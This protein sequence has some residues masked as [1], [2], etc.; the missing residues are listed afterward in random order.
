V[1]AEPDARHGLPAAL[2]GEARSKPGG[3]VYEIVGDY[4]PDGAEPPEAIRGAWRV[5]DQGEVEGE[6]IE[7]PNYGP[8]ALEGRGSRCRR[9]AAGVR[10]D[11]ELPHGPDRSDSAHWKRFFFW[12]VRHRSVSCNEASA[13]SVSAEVP[14]LLWGCP[15]TGKIS[16]ARAL[17]EA[18]GWLVEVVIGSIRDPSDIAELPV[19]A[20]SSVALAPAWAR[21]LASASEGLR[22]LDDLTT[23]PA[24]FQAAMLHIF[25]ARVVGD[26]WRWRP[27]DKTSVFVGLLDPAGTV[28]GW[29]KVDNLEP[30]G[31]LAGW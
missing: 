9:A 10:P 15:G 29:A 18:L 31:S 13:V 19:V 12:E 6:F 4:D 27:P 20:E 2:V 23:A 3:W 22:F 8:P 5:N 28:P 7:N 11:S 30:A 25:L 24:A 14:V 1:S 21:R 26:L 16:I 17:R